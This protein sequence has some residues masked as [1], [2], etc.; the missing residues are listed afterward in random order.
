MRNLRNVAFAATLIVLM[1][2]G[3]PGAA[4]ASI[5]WP[6]ISQNICNAIKSD[7]DGLRQSAV[8]RI[9]Q[10]GGLV[11]ASDMVFD[12]VSIFRDHDDALVR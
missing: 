5:D 7:N 8:Q 6:V 12:L 9:I 1:N 2:V 4:P 3:P 11:Y 10:Y